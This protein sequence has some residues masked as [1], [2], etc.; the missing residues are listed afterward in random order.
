[1]L[2]LSESLTQLHVAADTVDTA[3]APQK[4]QMMNPDAL[5][6]GGSAMDV[7][8]G[9]LLV[10]AAIYAVA[11]LLRRVQQGAGNDLTA[12]KVRAGLSVGPR[13][14]V[15]LVQAA[16]TYMLV[17]VA[18]GNVR[19]LHVFPEAPQLQDVAALA[20]NHSAAEGSDVPA[21]LR[22]LLPVSRS[23]RSV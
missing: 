20:P 17:A 4:L 11:W 23:T 6:L 3:A 16:Q 14:K 10:V 12:L 15:L 22:R 7:L 1:M 13:E 2:K 5:S 8:G 18:P 19:T 9:L 21:W